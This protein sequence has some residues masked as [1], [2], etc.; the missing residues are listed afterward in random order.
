MMAAICRN[1]HT[2]TNN[3]Q[4]R[5]TKMFSDALRSERAPLVSYYGA[6]AGLQELGPDV[7]KV[8]ILPNISILSQKIDVALD[9]NASNV[10]TSSVEKI[11]AQNIRT[12]L[13]KSVSPV[14][15]SLRDPP[16]NLEDFR[17]EFG[18]LG[19]HL[20]SGVERARRQSGSKSSASVASTP[21]RIQG[22]VNTPGSTQRTPSQQKV[23][24]VNPQIS[25]QS[26]QVQNIMTPQTTAQQ[27]RTVVMSEPSSQVRTVVVQDGGGQTTPQ[28]P[29][30][31]QTGGI[32]A[33]FPQN[34]NQQHF[35]PN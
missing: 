6:I 11:A 24:I 10:A 32:R 28:R 1:F 3:I 27:M 23:F 21:A 16:D 20:H 17:I 34:L 8:F 5:V 18:S 7:I 19:L 14:L 30:P 12:L 35:N 2:S 31:Q 26:A 29:A 33:V 22:L 9:A 25:Q 4:T 15:K 13:V